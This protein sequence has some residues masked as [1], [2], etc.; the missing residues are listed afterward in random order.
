MELKYRG[1][2]NHDIDIND[3]DLLEKIKT[4]I[5]NA[6]NAKSVSQIQQ[7]KKLRKYKTHYRIRIAENYRIGV[8]I[9]HK[10]IWF[11]C[12]GH[13]NIFYKNFP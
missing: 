8:I 6:K 13:R 3:R 11:V 9:R 7:L 4:S 5:L 12:F 2:F 1:T 10:T